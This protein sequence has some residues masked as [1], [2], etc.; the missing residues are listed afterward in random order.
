M[1]SYV[2]PFLLRPPALTNYALLVYIWTK[3]QEAESSLESLQ[4]HEQSLKSELTR[5][6]KAERARRLAAEERLQVM[7]SHSI[8]ILDH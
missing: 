1:L 2:S 8:Q 3:F 5:K 4:R 6:A 7:Y